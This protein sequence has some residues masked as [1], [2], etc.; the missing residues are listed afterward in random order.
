MG[1]GTAI[2]DSTTCTPSGGTPPYSYA[3][4]V[5]TYDGPVTP[6]AVSPTSATTGFRQTS[7]GISAYYVA[8]FRCL[9]TDSS[10]GTPFT[11]YSNLVSAFWSDVT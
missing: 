1:T 6:T 5:V 9:V 10:P 4:E 11:A 7:I 8:T 2:T 3:W